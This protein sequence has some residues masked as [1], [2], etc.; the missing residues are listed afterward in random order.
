M[1]ESLMTSLS[2]RVLQFLSENQGYNIHFIPLE[3]VISETNA[4]IYAA[5]CHTFKIKANTEID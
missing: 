3:T 5:S 2:E 4:W 1:K